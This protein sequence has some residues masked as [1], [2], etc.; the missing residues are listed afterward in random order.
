MAEE[1]SVV[2]KRLPR[3]QA[4]TMATGSAKYTVDIKLP[5]M[6]IGKVLRSPYAHARIV[7]I[8][9]SKAEKLPGVEAVITRED[10]PKKLFN[11]SDSALLLPIVELSMP[12]E[13]IFN[14]KAR[15]IGDAVAAVAAI[16]TR[17]AEE[18]LEL[19]KVDYE[20]LP[21]IFDPIEAIKPIA[22]RIH[23]FAANNIACHIPCTESHGDIEKGF[24]EADY[25]IEE[26]FR[27]SKQEHC[28]LEPASCVA[29]FEKTGMLTVWSPLQGAFPQRR[30][31]AEIF[32]IPEGTIRWLTPHVGGGFGNK[33]SLMAEPICIALAKKTGKPVKLEYAMEEQFTATE[34]REAFIQTGKMGVKKDGTITALQMKLI[35]DAGA[36]FT[37]SGA[38]SA[39][40]MSDFSGP[41]RCQSLQAEVDIV[42]TNITVSGGFRGYG[43]PAAMWLVEQL[44]DMACEKIGMDPVEFRLKNHKR[45]GEYG[46]AGFAI[47]TCALDECIKIGAERIGWKEKRGTKKGGTSRCGVGMAIMMHVTGAHNTLLEH[48]NAMVKLNVDGSASLI[49]SACD[50]GQNPLGA[51]AQIAAEELGL[52]AED[53]HIV[54]GDTDVTMFDV[55]QHASRTL[56]C[57]GNA[58]KRAAAEVKHQ[59][60]ERA[61]KK[62]G[63]SPNELEIRDRRIYVRTTPQKEISVAEVAKDAI[64]NFKGECL[65]ILGKCTWEPKENPFPFQAVFA[66]VEVDTETGAV[67]VLKIVVAHDIGRAINPTTVEGQLEGGVM[68]GVG[69]ALTEDFAINKDTGVVESDNF[70]TYKIPSTSE[71]PDIEVVLVEQ[72]VPSGPFGAKSV[73][74]S[75]MVAIAPAIANA[76]YDAV[77]IRIKD[78]PITPEKILKALGA[79]QK[80]AEGSF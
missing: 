68:Q 6:L 31:V 32:D 7:K 62:L 19:I 25:V 78:L 24:Q 58:V 66:E 48:T 65:N 11:R 47:E 5:G 40:C 60:L 51:L 9:K 20:V 71:M 41:Y 54:T 36:Y 44:V 42:Y 74:E 2:G 52:H 13:S 72:P 14:D 18:A 75:S 63:V 79:K 76:I 35:A 26:A 28:A 3:W 27:T 77:G 39:V 69:Y 43:N 10:V 55:G 73:G 15:H 70:G 80:Q 21:A 38:T 61:A 12:D 56:Y 8:D 30:N 22:L 57:I 17:T 46:K 49:V 67:K 53:I 29:S 16:D 34:T 50:M 33:L 4:H 59:L 64:Y 23:D 45:A 1:L 37:H